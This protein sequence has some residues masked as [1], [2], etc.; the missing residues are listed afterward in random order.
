MIASL[1]ACS[2]GSS[3]KSPAKPGQGGAAGTGGSIT[4]DGGTDGSFGCVPGVRGCWGKTLYDCGADGASRTNEQQCPD[5]CDP[6]LGCVFCSPGTRKCE[7]TV[8]MVCGADASSLSYGRDC[9]EWNSE[10]SSSGFCSDSCGQA[11]STLS[12]V[13]CEYWPT[14]L[15]NTSELNSSLF[16]YRVVVANPG[17]KEASV[18]VTRGT[19]EVYTGKV[20]PHG[21]QEIKLPWI[22]GQSFGIPGGD[23]KSI[24]TK[25]GAYRL[26]SSEPVTVSQFNPFEYKADSA[27]TAVFSYTNDATLLLP[28]HVLT[29]DYV[30][31]T[32]LPFTRGTGTGAFPP[33]FMKFANYLAIVGVTPEPADVS[34]TVA[35]YSAVEAQGR[36]QAAA[37]GET[38]SFQLARGEVA[39]VASAPPPNCKE[40]RPGWVREEECT[41]GMCDYMDTCAE[42]EFDLTGS[43]VSSNRHVEVFGGHV[44]AYVPY[45]SQACDHLETQ[46]APIQTW[47]KQFVSRPM[48]DQGGPGDNL[49]RVTAAFDNTDITVAPEQGGFSGST[50]H[51][52]QWSEFMA[53]TPFVVSGTQAIQV[54]QFL[55]GQYYSKP[56]ANRGDPGMTVLVPSEQ[57]RAD[58]I[59]ITPSS[60]NESTNGQNYVLIVRPP[61]LDL[62]LDGASVSANWEAVGGK[63]VGIVA[64][65]GG[66]HTIAGKDK[67]GM[68]AYGLGTFTSYAYPAGLDLKKITDVVK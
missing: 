36:F 38:I 35:G 6:K 4:L 28:T 10:C 44:C 37:P 58:Y 2:A 9:A 61:A 25:D 22:D 23:W 53:S 15:T 42:A 3:S 34:V 43:R 29:G 60:Y 17:D 50:L 62:T 67:F 51:A 31:V 30:A 27:G 13:G 47:G 24:V 16:D 26:R 5:A 39:H 8:S 65:P 1:A 48:T 33:D 59:F 20:A 63:E 18:K 56:E 40:G 46:L 14:P 12:Y 52:G 54:A 55:V 45:T 64:V 41:M 68:I 66:T 57:Y 19:A 49:V 21:L 7:G 11:E 32:Y